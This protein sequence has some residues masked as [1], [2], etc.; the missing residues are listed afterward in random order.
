M[1]HITKMCSLMRDVLMLHVAP[2]G[3][4]DLLSG[5]YDSATLSDFARRMTT[6]ELLCAMETLQRST[7]ALRDAKNPTSPPHST[8]TPRERG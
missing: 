6:E 7:D 5:G 1:T 3:A 4:Q 2:K 8:P